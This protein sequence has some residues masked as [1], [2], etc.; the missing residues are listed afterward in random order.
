MPRYRFHLFSIHQRNFASCWFF[1]D[2]SILKKVV[3]DG[4]V[5]QCIHEYFSSIGVIFSVTTF[6]ILKFVCSP[7]SFL[8]DFLTD[9]RQRW[10]LSFKMSIKFHYY[11]VHIR[12]P[13]NVTRF[14]ISVVPSHTFAQSWNAHLLSRRC[15]N[16]FQICRDYR[17][18]VCSI[19]VLFVPFMRIL[20]DD[21]SLLGIHG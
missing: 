10:A 12:R 16:K 5:E 20:F 19:R 21:I 8:R 13:G 3:R 15:A 6:Y 9:Q 14:R 17:Y 4:Q 11:I 18:Q 1:F 2:F 7:H